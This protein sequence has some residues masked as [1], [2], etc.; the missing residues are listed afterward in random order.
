MEENDEIVPFLA[1]KKDTYRHAGDVRGN[2]DLTECD[3][4]V[5]VNVWSSYNSWTLNQT[6]GKSLSY[7]HIALVNS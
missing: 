1:C 7:H 3:R 5:G 4:V 2:I 6:S